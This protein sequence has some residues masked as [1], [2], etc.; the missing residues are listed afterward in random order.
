MSD[1]KV[2]LFLVFCFA[3]GSSPA[4]LSCPELCKVK[5]T[6]PCEVPR[7][8]ARGLST[9]V[10]PC[11]VCNTTG[12]A[13]GN[14]LR[15]LPATLKMLQVAG[16]SDSNRELK[17]LPGLAQLRTLILGPGRILTVGQDI[18]SA[19]PNVTTLALG[20]NAISA[21]GSWFGDISKLKSLYLSWNKVQEI[22]E[23]ALQP[24]IWL[25][26]LYLSH[27]RIRAIEEWHF[28]DLTNLVYLYL[29]NNHISRIAGKC[30]DH[31][32]R[33][34]VLNL[35]HNK[36]LSLNAEWLKGLGA[37]RNANFQHNLISAIPG[38][39]LTAMG[40]RLR[41]INLEENPLRCTCALNSL[42]AVRA[43]AIMGED[44]YRRLRCSYPP[45]V[46]GRRVA[47]VEEMICPVPTVRVSLRN[48][49]RTLMCEVFWEKQP[50][51]IRWLDP[52]ENV[53]GKGKS[54]TSSSECSG[55]VTTRLEHEFP[56]TEFPGRGL[57]HSALPYI[58][59]STCIISMSQQAYRCWKGGVFRCIVQ[60][61]KWRSMWDL[62]VNLT[63]NVPNKA[64]GNGHMQEETTV[65]TTVYTTAPAQWYTN[66]TAPAPLPRTHTHVNS[67]VLS[68]PEGLETTQEEIPDQLPWTH[69]YVTSNISS[70]PHGTE[71]AQTEEMQ[72]PTV[73]TVGT[74][75]YAQWH[76]NVTER[77]RNTRNIIPQQTRITPGADT[78][79]PTVMIA[80]Y[81]T[82]AC[83][84]LV[85][86]GVVTAVG[87]KF[88]KRRR[89]HDNTAG[90]IGGGPLQNDLPPVP[91][92]STNPTSL[93]Q[94]MHEAI[95]NDNDSPTAPIPPPRPDST[96]NLKGRETTQA[97]DL[98]IPAPLPRI[99]TNVNSGI[100]SQPHETEATHEEIPAPLP[101]IHTNVNS[102]ISS[103][104]HETEATHEEIPAPLPRIHTNVN[105]GISSQPHET[106][107]T[108]EEI[109]A[110][111]PRIHTNVN[112]GISS[113]PHETEATHEEIPAPLPRTHTHVNSSISSQPHETEATHEE[114]PAPLPRTHTHVNSS[115]SSHLQ[116]TETT[117][118][119]KSR[120]HSHGPTR[121][122]TNQTEE[123]PDPLPRI[124]TYV[125]SSVLSH[126][127]GSEIKQEEI[128]PPLPRTHTYVNSSVLS[129][130]QG[131]DATQEEIRAPLPRIHTYV[132]TSVLSQQHDPKTT[133]AEEIPAPLPR[134]HTYVNCSVS[135][136][137]EGS[138]TTHEH[139]EIP[140]P[141]ARTHTHVNSD[142]Q[143]LALVS[144]TGNP[145]PF[146]HTLEET[147]GEDETSIAA[148]GRM[149]R[150]LE[151]PVFIGDVTEPKCATFNP[152]SCLRSGRSTNPSASL[153]PD[154]THTGEVPDPPPQ[155]DN[156]VNFSSS[157]CPPIPETIK[158]EEL[159]HPLTQVYT[160]YVNSNVSSQPL[161]LKMTQAESIR[162]PLS[163]THTYVNS[164]A[165]LQQE[166]SEIHQDEMPDPLP[167]IHM[168][169]NSSVLSQPEGS[170]IHQDEISDPL[171]RTHT[172]VN[173][174]VLSQPEGLEIH[175]EEI[176]DQLPRTHTYVNS[177]VLSQPEGSEI[178]QDEISDP[179]SRTHTYVNSSVLSQPEGLEIHQEEI[180]DQLPRTHTYVNSSVLSQSQGL[181]IHQEEII[182]DQLPRI[183]TYVNSSV[184]SQSQGLEIHQ[185]EIPDQ[186]PRTHT[187]VNSNIHSP[188]S[189]IGQP[190]PF[191]HTYK[192]TLGEDD[193]S[194]AVYGSMTR[195]LE[196][197]MYSKDIA[198][199]K[200]ATANSA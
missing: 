21:I 13:G 160:T 60:L 91:A 54:Y 108:H 199:P 43:R 64:S 103:Q 30:F 52:T 12:Q 185:D 177:S 19:V 145:A 186:L 161:G 85:F 136:Q 86:L 167:R 51:N 28:A 172:Y 119:K 194:I 157:Y 198:E 29:D 200:G 138:E 47:E 166:G 66:E 109:P 149:T 134:I 76:K 187:Y 6:E 159:P 9:S 137:L 125:N 156:S 44:A 124:H 37:L 162:D 34:K 20:R 175:Q 77:M 181:E 101:R 32:S 59:K 112:S 102:G 87:F 132:N 129:K 171:P 42:K 116:G 121:P 78:K 164:N 35:A 88:Y 183:H 69:T 98:E 72:E 95:P 110:P 153:Q 192:A 195:L 117:Q 155:V 80:V 92:T 45:S 40:E 36:L 180:P 97:E 33:L 188:A 84:A 128:P 197:T 196:N 67:S 191:Q 5:R 144:A 152:D 25:E 48:A 3:F 8:I 133:Q 148:Y 46:S 74:T 154:Q 173:S 193:T 96:F 50:E 120:L 106:E 22:K 53:V 49:G 131:L 176:P 184:L 105:S 114:I 55:A 39:Q 179:L 113:Q 165:L 11:A 7:E 73:T 89:S 127:Q 150:L 158:A 182:P 126:S 147:W 168:Y 79:E 104:P 4:G 93:Q 62:D 1:L 143:L 135:S 189:T 18:L 15:C 130:Q 174:S 68:Q 57:A 2:S 146:Q 122:K 14:Q 58:G 100:S 26:S 139:E 142:N 90:A 123:I 65:M 27:N 115:V 56:I 151:N 71:A 41:F 38:D 31:L 163:Q 94:D 178:H 107:A 81:T 140:D 16:H 190:T 169:V 17:T 141:F 24:L 170:E 63:L 99:H 111:L 23:N 10:L 83:L 75:A 70:Q 82:S 118:Q 61:N